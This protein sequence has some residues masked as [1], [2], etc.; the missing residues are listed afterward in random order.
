MIP[1][2]WDPGRLPECEML[3][4][5][6]VELNVMDF[7]ETEYKPENNDEMRVTKRKL[8]KEKNRNKKMLG[9]KCRKGQGYNKRSKNKE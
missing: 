5:D 6:E 1:R 8:P 9:G 7:V 2:D 4:E 3:Q